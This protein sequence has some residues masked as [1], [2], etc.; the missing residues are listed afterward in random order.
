MPRIVALAMFTFHWQCVRKR[1]FFKLCCNWLDERRCAWV[2]MCLL[3]CWLFDSKVFLLSS[4]PEGERERKER[5]T[6]LVIVSRH[7]PAPPQRVS[8]PSRQESVRVRVSHTLNHLLWERAI[9]HVCVPLYYECRLSVG[10][11]VCVCVS[12]SYLKILQARQ[13][14]ICIRE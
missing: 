8:V 10:V 14:L 9:L 7:K 11:C 4:N 12:L 2:C 5:G 3:F 1:A 6:S 13:F